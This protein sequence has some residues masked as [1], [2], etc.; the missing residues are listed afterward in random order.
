MR[1][2]KGDR[3]DKGYGMPSTQTESACLNGN[4]VPS[5]KSAS[6]AIHE[7]TEGLQH[8]GQPR[9]G[10]ACIHGGVFKSAMEKPAARLAHFRTSEGSTHM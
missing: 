9:H 8:Q 7:G 6:N 3:Q 5:C 1:Q 4:A 2:D 10:P